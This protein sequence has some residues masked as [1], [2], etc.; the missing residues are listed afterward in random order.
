MCHSIVGGLVFL[1]LMVLVAAAIWGCI[2]LLTNHR[3]ADE[4]LYKQDEYD[5]MNI[6]RPQPDCSHFCTEGEKIRPYPAV[7]CSLC[8]GKGRDIPNV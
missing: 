5:Y 7:L 2:W 4:R 6:K 3:F 8:M 1:I